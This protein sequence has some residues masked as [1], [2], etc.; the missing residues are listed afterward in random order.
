MIAPMADE[1]ASH[2]ICWLHLSDLHARLRDGW[3]TKEITAALI[4]DLRSLN[5]EHGIR[6]NFVV[7]T[8]DCAFGTV[9]GESMT[10]QYQQARQFFDGVRQAFNPEIPI[11]DLY[12]V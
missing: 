2:R 5:R 11:R 12:L 9:P 8:G 7:F 6:P 10:Q 4:T 1:L 3:D